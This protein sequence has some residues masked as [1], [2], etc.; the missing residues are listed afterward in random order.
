MKLKFEF[1][2]DVKFSVSIDYYA[3]DENEILSR[4][5]ECI[6]DFEF[7][8]RDATLLDIIE[9]YLNEEVG[10]ELS[11]VNSKVIKN[12][13]EFSGGE[14]TF[15]CEVEFN[16]N[17]DNHKIIGVD[18]EDGFYQE[19]MNALTE[20]CCYIDTY[21]IYHDS[22]EFSD[23]N[24]IASCDIDTIKYSCEIVEER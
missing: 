24:L 12:D 15:D 16:G 8:F 17:I 5:E 20:N 4:I 13:S 10:V 9:T 19:F 11:N 18:W 6:D 3:T 1:S 14:I 21:A 23:F 7:T 2:C 22:E